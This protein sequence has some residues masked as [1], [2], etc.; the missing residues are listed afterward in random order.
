MGM[1]ADDFVLKPVNFL[2]LTIRVKKLLSIY[3]QS[4]SQKILQ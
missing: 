3:E 4:K 2:E 1:G